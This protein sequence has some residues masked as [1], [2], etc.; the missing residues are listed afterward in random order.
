M[1]RK[2]QSGKSRSTRKKTVQVIA[3]V[4]SVFNRDSNFLESQIEGKRVELQIDT[5]SQLTLL[6]I[7]TWHC[8][9]KPKLNE[10]PYKLQS[11]SKEVIKVKGQCELQVEC[12]GKKKSLEAIFTN[13][14]QVNLLGRIWVR[15]L[16]L[17]LNNLFVALVKTEK[18]LKTLLTRYAVPFRNELGRCTKIKAQLHFKENVI[19]QFIRP[20][21]L[22]FALREAAESDLKKRV[23]NSVLTPVETAQSATP[24]VI[25]LKTSGL[26]K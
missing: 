5:G 26:Q 24:I 20:R 10:T 9:G 3:R 6:D 21:P 16:K 11:F 19:P 14:S 12:Q 7:K 8:L 22:P 17:D 23:A 18:S 15:A 13:T 1:C 25:V 4:Q 2:G